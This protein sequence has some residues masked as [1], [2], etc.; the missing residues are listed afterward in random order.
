MVDIFTRPKL[1]TLNI[2]FTYNWYDTKAMSTLFV[3][4]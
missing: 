4:I 2:I 1:N 3:T